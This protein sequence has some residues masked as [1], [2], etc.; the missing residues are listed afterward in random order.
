MLNWQQKKK[1]IVKK[2]EAKMNAKKVPTKLTLERI[3]E[4]EEAVE[5][6]IPKKRTPLREELEKE[7]FA[8]KMKQREE[9]RKR[10]F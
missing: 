4:R 8:M 1:P 10:S 9:S 2:E 5:R 7:E 3:E 6:I